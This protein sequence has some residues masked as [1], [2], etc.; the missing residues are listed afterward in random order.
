MLSSLIHIK[1]LSWSRSL[2]YCSVYISVEYSLNT[3]FLFGDSGTQEMWEEQLPVKTDAKKLLKT[4]VFSIA[5]VTRS[6]VLFITRGVSKS[7]EPCRSPWRSAT[8]C[9]Q[10]IQHRAVSFSVT[11][12]SWCKEEYNAELEAV[13]WLLLKLGSIELTVKFP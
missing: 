11:H 4:S 5:V 10:K 6:P 13:Q 1:A 2:V 3:F 7:A 9:Y 8:W 12:M